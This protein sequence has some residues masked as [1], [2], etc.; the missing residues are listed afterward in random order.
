[1]VNDTKAPL[2]V[3]LTLDC[4][5]LVTLEGSPQRKLTLAAGQRGREYFVLDVTGQKGNCDLTFHGTCRAGVP[6]AQAAGTAAL[7]NSLRDAVTRPLHVVPPGFPK[8]SSYSGQLSGPQELDVKLP[9]HWVPGSLEV[10]LN[11]F[12]SSLADLQKGLRRHSARAQR[13]LR[14]GIH[15]ELP[16]RDDD[17]VH[18]AARRGRSGGRP[19]GRRTCSKRATHG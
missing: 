8:V 2:P 9:E 18:A 13:L 11:V 16:E 15:V 17:A 4:G 14:A 6:P 10:S 12:P 5:K 7:Q 3:E 19:R 1:M